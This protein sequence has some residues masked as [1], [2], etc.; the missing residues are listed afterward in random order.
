MEFPSLNWKASSLWALWAWQRALLA[1]WLQCRAVVWLSLHSW[2]APGKGR[3]TG[4]FS[5]FVELCLCLSSGFKWKGRSSSLFPDPC[6]PSYLG[7]VC[8]QHGHL[9]VLS[10]D[11]FWL[12]L[13]GWWRGLLV[14]SAH[15]DEEEE[16]GNSQ[17]NGHT[18]HQNIQDFH[19]ILLFGI[20][21]IWVQGEKGKCY[22]G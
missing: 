18:W 16:E 21:G 4:S 17:G 12:P 11:R 3:V 5:V 22:T 9:Y 8:I 19:F 10:S 2:V 15:T 6:H 1:S 20:F 14:I 7:L 13:D